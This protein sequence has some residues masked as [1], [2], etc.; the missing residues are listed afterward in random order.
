MREMQPQ[1]GTGRTAGRSHERR[2]LSV[3]SIVLFAVV[4]TTVLVLAH[5][6]LRAVFVGL[7]ERSDRADRPRPPLRAERVVPP[8]PRLQT[9]PGE[10]LDAL[11]R[12]EERRLGTYG[13][14]DRDRRVLRI[15]I[16][17]AIDQVLRRGLPARAP[18][19]E[20]D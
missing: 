11:R 14:I 5:F 18:V 16:D 10:D 15:P 2:D 3:R 1:G 9:N 6:G 7:R 13:W 20:A 4:L 17:R 19:R 8:E 12:D